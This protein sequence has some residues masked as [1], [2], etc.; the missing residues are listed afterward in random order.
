MQSEPLIINVCLTGNVPTKKD[1]LHV[2]INPDEIIQDAKAVI[3]EGATVLH[4]HARDKD[5]NPTFEKRIFETIITGIRKVNSE[6]V[7]CV[8]TSGRI[9]K[10]FEERTQVLELRGRAKPDFASLTLGSFNFPKESCE[11]SPKMIAAI[12]QKMKDR[13]ILPEW[14]I[15]EPGMIHYGKYLVK[16]GILDEPR[17]INIF[18]GSLG[19]SPAE[20]SVLSLFLGM[21]KPGWRWAATGVGRYQLPVNLMSLSHG[22]HIRV[23]LEDSFF[24]DEEKKEPATNVLLVRRIVQI[25]KSYGRKIATIRQVR[26]MLFLT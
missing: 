1:N 3:R 8:T 14:E 17:W 15:F 18:L 13:G 11:N 6:V 19:T 12:A 26:G 22:G 25:A 21:I 20:S 7:I 9:N 23:G 10:T 24:M 4:I 2:P 16:N 5:G